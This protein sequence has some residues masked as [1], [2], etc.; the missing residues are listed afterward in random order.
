MQ[1]FMGLEEWTQVR[2]WEYNTQPQGN[3]MIFSLGVPGVSSNRF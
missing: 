2:D 3:G 1:V